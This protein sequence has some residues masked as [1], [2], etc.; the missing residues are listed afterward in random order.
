MIDIAGYDRAVRIYESQVSLVLRARRQEDG[1][2]V[3]LKILKNAYPSARDLARYRH[4]YA[5]LGQLRSDRI[6]GSSGL[7][8]YGNTLVLVLEDFGAQS[9]KSLLQIRPLALP[10]LLRIALDV[11]RGL[12]ELHGSQII[13]K[14][15]N[16]SNIVHN[17]ESGQT[18]LIDLG[19]AATVSSSNPH[20]DDTGLLEGTLAYISPE[21]TGRMNRSVDYRSDLYSLGVTLYEL[22]TG[23]LPFSANHSLELVHAHIA[24]SPRPIREIRPELP[25]ILSSIVDRLMAKTAEARYQSAA[26]LAHDLEECL[27]RLENGGEISPFVLGQRDRL[28]VFYL[29]QKL[30]GRDREIATLL[31]A[32]ERCA[33]GEGAWLLVSGYSGTG[34]TSL[35]KEVHKPIARLRGYFIEGKF[36]QYQRATP[37]SAIRQAIVELV[38]VWLAEPDERLARRRDE[39]LEVIGDLGQVLFEVAPNL[40]LILGPQPAVPALSGMESQNRF[41]L[42]CRRFFKA[43]AEHPLVMFIDDLQWADLA[44]LNLLS[45]LITDP[46]IR[47]LLLIGAYRDNEVG[48]S[49]PLALMIDRMSKRGFDPT[50]IRI[51]NLALADVTVL[52]GDVLQSE[53]DSVGEL[54]TLIQRKTLGNPFFVSQC[55][56]AFH[57]EG[58]IRY[59]QAASAW[60]WDV[61]AIQR[62]DITENVVELMAA[63]IRSLVPETRRMLELA[64]C[65]G[66]R[67]DRETLSLIAVSDGPGL[68]RALDEGVTEGL[69]IRYGEG[70]YRFSHDR[71]QQAAY[72]LIADTERESRH[73]EIG[74]LLLRGCDASDRS[75]RVFEIVDQL[76]AGRRLILDPDERLELTQLNRE[77]ATKAKDAAAFASAVGYLRVAREL[78]AADSC[79]KQRDLVFAL[80]CEL[81]V[82]LCFAGE[83]DEI[84]PLFAQLL[85][86][87]RGPEEKVAVHRIR[88]EHYHLRGDYARAVEIQKEAL[89]L[90]GIDVPGEAASLQ[91]LL[92]REIQDVSRLLGARSIESL[93][94]A[95]PMRSRH[96]QTVMDI[97]MGLW[98]SAYLDSQP[99][100]VAWASCRMTNLSLEHG[101]NHLTSYAYM[102]Y[103]FVCVALLDEYARG[104]RFG[105]VAIRLSDR[106]ENRLIRGKVYLLFAVFVNHWRAPLIDSL[107][108]SLKSFPLL[109]ESGDWT[110]AGY[111]AEFVISDP[112]I[113]GH[114]CHTLYEEAQRYIPFLQ[115]NA[116]VVLDSFFRPA[117]L[118]PLL[119][120]MALTQNDATFDDGVFSE[121]AFLDAHRDNP[122]ALSYFYTAKLR[123]LYW[124]GHLDA[125]L[126]MVDKADFVASVALAQAKVPEIYFFACLTLLER[127][128]Q[129]SSGERAGYRE[130]IAGYQSRMSRW[131]QESPANFRHK[132]SLV[133]AELARVDGDRWTALTLYEQAIDAAREGGYLNNEALAYERLARFYLDQGLDRSAAFYMREAR[134]AYLKWGAAAK[135]AQLDREHRALLTHVWDDSQRGDRLSME[136]STLTT[137]TFEISEQSETLDLFSI[138][139]ASQSLAS[140]IHLDGLLV[141]M[142]EI[143]MEHAGADRCLLIAS[144]DARLYL[145]AETRADR[146]RVSMPQDLAVEDA[147]D[148][149]P[150]SLIH[151]C[152]RTRQQIVLADA[153]EEDGYSQDPYFVASA[154]RSALCVPLLLRGE[155]AGLLYVENSLAR[156][157]F[158]DKLLRILGLLSTQIAISI[159]NADFY[160][161]LE[162]LV[163]KRTEELSQVNDQLR[164][165]NEELRQLS[166]TDGLTRLANRRYLD[167]YL[168]REWRRH[169][170]RGLPL[171][172]ALCDIDYFKQYNDT[173]GH[174]AGD[175]CL[176]GVARALDAAAGREV[177]LVARYG[178][179]EF[180]L[181]LPDTDEKGARTMIDKIRSNI[182]ALAIPHARSDVGRHVTISIGVYQGVPSSADV[183]TALSVADQCLYAAKSS[184][185]DCAVL[186][187]VMVTRSEA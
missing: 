184:G 137:G 46:G 169:L 170:R 89:R 2:S 11:A 178:G 79:G 173:Y 95:P 37:Y 135:I 21:Q 151:Y 7:I 28:E 72:S 54:A 139:E 117:C 113:C 31:D 106:C 58:L 167:E 39:I 100:L 18:K 36:D 74:R 75:R 93:V 20:R 143:V 32:F 110:Y 104:H 163:A 9:L 84:E 119:H 43:A 76:N 186:N 51:G 107:D 26:G 34:K 179:E 69:L 129:F 80:L 47:H 175:R 15:V 171:V 168:R 81:S 160:R 29:P 92:E 118:N 86:R 123:A 127:Y 90:L 45:A 68:D 130:K 5:M 14:D 156:D 182:E 10:N 57:A 183:A 63:K 128:P 1:L 27:I 66:N 102:N 176:V 88:M 121:A 181:V 180:A 108:Y 49:H 149:L 64:A 153:G 185:R 96:H 22:L 126:A 136:R 172:I 3:I 33:Q 42:V 147:G 77:A 24:R 166:T 60:T 85:E 122:L 111:C 87:A 174:L 140:E 161:R 4:E 70:L 30:Y 82:C 112:M 165:A 50:G 158:T 91:A 12:S 159:Q 132:Q 164:Q 52:A 83:T 177:D 62:C 38:D 115:T 55:L 150:L 19:I 125:A 148:R 103:G 73:L 53:S 6:I 48:P 99:E 8:E 187:A 40:E 133:A 16:P 142:M 124:L 152:A 23:S 155:L 131:A 59:D 61:A 25:G 162:S 67:F 146:Q 97:L 94:D 114:S 134:Y 65:I 98:T 120:L 105:Q 154:M 41:N 145:R 56:M 35:I 71:I 116:P 17:P 78:L 141:R 138:V 109:V 157:A 13:H 101:N 144:Q 44:S